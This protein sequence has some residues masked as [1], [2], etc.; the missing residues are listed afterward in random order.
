MLYA[1]SYMR[2]VIIHMNHATCYTMSV[3]CYIMHVVLHIHMS[4]CYITVYSMTANVIGNRLK[5][6]EHRSGNVWKPSG[7]IRTAI[8]IHS[9]QFQ[10]VLHNSS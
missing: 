1:I 6:A 4:W 8:L 5:I 10:L 7:R 2:H 9:N 3:V